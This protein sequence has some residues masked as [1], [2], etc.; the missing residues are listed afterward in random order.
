[1]R[2]L[3]S[4]AGKDLCR[5]TGPPAPAPTSALPVDGGFLLEDLVGGGDERRTN[6]P[7]AE[8]VRVTAGGH[9]HASGVGDV[10]TTRIKDEQHILGG[11]LDTSLGTALDTSF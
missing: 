4:C 8:H 7:P 3:R 1:M 5:C 9:L 11:P 6:Q 2:L 10:D